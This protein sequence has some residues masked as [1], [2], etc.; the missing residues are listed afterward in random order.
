MSIIP[1]RPP[2]TPLMQY[3]S[4][5]R[6]PKTIKQTN[7]KNISAEPG[8]AAKIGERNKQPNEEIDIK[9]VTQKKHSAR[10][11]RP[12]GYLKPETCEINKQ[13]RG[14]E[15]MGITNLYRDVAN[16]NL[17]MNKINNMVKDVE[18][19]REC[20]QDNFDKP[21]RGYK[22]AQ[23][24]DKNNFERLRSQK[25]DS[26]RSTGTMRP[27]RGKEIAE[28]MLRHVADENNYYNNKKHTF[29]SGSNKGPYE[30]TMP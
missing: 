3:Y 14:K 4:T 25:L 16:N 23:Q 12:D 8:N 26:Q 9:P 21:T 24:T 7:Y 10:F 17:H 13:I 27:S 19:N 20:K 11:Y 18:K 29:M 30:K 6:Y 1:Q 15:A 2:D 5:G 28:V 22:Q